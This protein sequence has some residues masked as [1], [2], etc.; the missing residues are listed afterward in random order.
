MASSYEEMVTEVNHKAP[1]LYE[2]MYNEEEKD[3]PGGPPVETIAERV[4][5][6]SIARMKLW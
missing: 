4:V 3:L 6:D 2:A 1:G 5:K